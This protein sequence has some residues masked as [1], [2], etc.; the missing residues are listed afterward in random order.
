MILDYI[1]QNISQLGHSL[2]TKVGRLHAYFM[3]F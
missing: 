3:H 1:I 2:A